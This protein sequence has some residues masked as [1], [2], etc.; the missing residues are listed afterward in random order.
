MVRKLIEW[1]VSNPLVAGLLA[2]ALAI[3]GGYA[4]FNVNVEAYPDPAPAIIEVV[5]QYPGASAEEVERQVTIPLEVALSGMPGLQ[6]TRSKSLFGLA[7]LRNQFDYSV[8]YDKAK[9]DVINRLALATLPPGVT[10]QISPA[11]PTGEI[12]RYTLRSPKDP[13]GR[14]Y[15]TLADLK[16]LQDYTLQREL[17]RVPRI[18]GVVGAGGAIKRYEIQPDPNRLR[19]YGI[20]LAQLASALGAGN[21]NGS[22]DNLTQ[23]QTNLV[24][25][26]VGLYGGG[27]DPVQQALS[28]KSPAEAAAFLRAEDAR[29]LREIRQTVV[30]SVNSVPVRADHVVEGGPLLHADGTARVSDEV[31]VKQGV[32]VAHQTRQG[33][34]SISRPR[35]DAEGREV[36]GRDGQRAWEDEDEAVQGIVLLRKGQESLPALGDVVAKI[37]ELNKPGHLLPGVVVEAYYNRTELIGVTTETVRHNLL[38]GMALVAMILLMFLSN[39]RVALIVA[40]N[41]PLALLFAFAVLFARGRSANLL[42]IGAVDFGI[43]VDS[44]VILVESIYRHLTSGDYADRPLSERVVRA[45]A[46]V[47]RSVFFSTVIMVCALLPLFT[48]KGPEGQIFGPMADTYAFALGGALLLALTISPVLCCLL[49]KHVRAGRDNFLVRSLQSLYLSQLRVLL[50]LRW[51]ALV[52]FVAILAVT[53]VT[54]ANMGREFMPELEEGNLFIRGTFPINVSL[55]EVAARG[56]RVRELLRK[57]TEVAVLVPMI[58]RPDDGTDPTGY[59]NMELFVP[60]KAQKEWPTPPGADRPRTKEELIRRMNDDLD[61]HFPGVDWDFSQIIRDNVMEALSGVKGEN[62]IKVF[63]PD[64]GKLEDLAFQIKEKITPKYDADGRLVAGVHGVENAGVFRIRGQSNLEVPVDRQ[65]C[66][67]WG[68]SVAD[69]QNVVQTAVGGKAVAQMTEGERLFDITLRFPPTLR[70][71]EQAILNIPVDLTNY[72]VTAATAA[73]LAPTPVSGVVSLLSPTGTTIPLPAPS[74]SSN[75]GPALAGIPRRRLGDLVTPLNEKGQPDEDGSFVRPGASTIYREQGQRLI[76]IKFGVRGRDLASTVAEAQAAV[77]LLLEAPYRAEWSGEFQEMEEAETR[78]AKWFGLSLVLIV[79]LLYLAFRS[80]LDAGVVLAN[81][82]AM[83]IGGVWALKL[84]GLNFNISAAVGFISILGVAVMNGLLFVSAFNRYRARGLCLPEVLT[85]GTRQLVR[86]V[87]MTALAAILGLLP[88][89]FST[90]I[91]SQSQRPLAVVVVGGM[92]A[93]LL[94]MNLVPVLYSFY[95]HREP[96]EG[97]GAMGH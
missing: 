4:F 47:E 91:G 14:P 10:P 51:V 44:T 68:V 27:R 5:A 69:I 90:A 63:G 95:G 77:A 22:G 1:A 46:E 61:R 11:S 7:H 65:K 58:G 83:A 32:V 15:Y 53:G 56:R 79:L 92:L 76:A 20:S 2:A 52:S 87:T 34:V 80:F 33:K 17:L 42:S 19:Q 97:A 85:E 48:M 64:L 72:Q 84:V 8:D 23:G 62:S 71:S 50:P 94:C 74:G 78:M 67:R 25:R 16:A 13:L 18:A 39:V 45:C 96:P 75:D 86:P 49:L 60:L 21:G 93:T 66:A 9:Q 88:A 28:M 41:V 38:V 12:L 37:D 29:R 40:L 43:I 59:Y 31:L 35:T 24:V 54:A 55:D 26:A 3:G 89:A 81:V 30:A 82:L 70:S 57:Y 36:R 73:A 6:S